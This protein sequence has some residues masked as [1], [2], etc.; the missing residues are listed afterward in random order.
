MG[1]RDFQKLAR[2][3]IAAEPTRAP[4]AEILQHAE[5]LAADAERLLATTTTLIDRRSLGSRRSSGAATAML[6]PRDLPT[7]AATPA[8]TSNPATRRAPIHAPATATAVAAVD[9]SPVRPGRLAP[10]APGRSLQPLD[11]SRRIQP[12]SEPMLG[13]SQVV[14]AAST[15]RPPIQAPNATPLSV[16]TPGPDARWTEPLRSESNTREQAHAEIDRKLEAIYGVRQDGESVIF[17]SHSVEATE[18]QIAGD[19]NDWMPHTTPMRRLADG[20]FETR[21]KLPKGRY[22]YR[23]VV[24]GR[25]SHDLYNPII[26]TNEYG[27]LNSVV[28][29]KQ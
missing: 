21:L 17:R 29:I 1:A 5:R 3:I 19:F 11:P 15:A 14:P 4:T 20:D 25:W 8:T 12:I 10:I 9:S 16:P 28:E 26:E 22:R 18:I 13:D 2:E 23:L 27:E 24:D 6:P 7:P